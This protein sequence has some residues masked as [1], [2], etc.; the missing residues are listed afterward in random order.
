MQL[1]G[2]LYFVFG[3]NL[4]IDDRSTRCCYVGYSARIQQ[5]HREI[6]KDFC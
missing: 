6:I 3:Y 5:G 4:E 2:K 1:A